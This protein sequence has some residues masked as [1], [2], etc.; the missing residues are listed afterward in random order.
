MSFIQTGKKD[1]IQ[2]NVVIPN[3]VLD[4]NTSD[5]DLQKYTYV[6]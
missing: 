4:K 1:G 5:A 2:A 3:V 6:S